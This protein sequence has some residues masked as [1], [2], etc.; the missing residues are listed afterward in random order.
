MKNLGDVQIFD[1]GVLHVQVSVSGIPLTLIPP[2][3]DRAIAAFHVDGS[4]AM[5]MT[6]YREHEGKNA[7]LT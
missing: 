3:T 2:C 4:E 7:R 1:D 5:R 6:T